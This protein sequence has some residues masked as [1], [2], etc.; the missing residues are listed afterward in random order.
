[1]GL[2]QAT[3]ERGIKMI[4]IQKEVSVNEVDKYILVTKQLI[5]NT[6]RNIAGLQQRRGK[7]LIELKNLT[8]IKD[9]AEKETGSI[10]PVDPALV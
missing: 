10:D 1:M 6:D 7:L 2:T 9:S 8:D 4:T 3:E 5:E